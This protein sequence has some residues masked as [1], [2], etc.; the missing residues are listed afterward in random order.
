MYRY[1]SSLTSFLHEA[2][3]VVQEFFA[4]LVVVEFIQL[5]EEENIWMRT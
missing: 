4:L 2:E 3:E 1:R 5:L